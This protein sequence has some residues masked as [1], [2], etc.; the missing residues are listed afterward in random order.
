MNPAKGE[1][2][3]HYQVDQAFLC[4]QLALKSGS[5]VFFTKVTKICGYIKLMNLD[6][7]IGLLKTNRYT[8]EVVCL[9]VGIK[10]TL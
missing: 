6:F 10:P 9:L 1:I 7:R 2:Q 3:K 8:D 5:T 4:E